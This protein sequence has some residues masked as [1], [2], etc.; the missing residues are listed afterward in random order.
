ME[1]ISRFIP[2]TGNAFKGNFSTWNV[3]DGMESNQKNCLTC[4]CAIVCGR[5]ECTNA[6]V[7][8]FS[9]AEVGK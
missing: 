5:R 8:Y 1:G 2:T 9:I 4:K 6:F 7:E 3:V